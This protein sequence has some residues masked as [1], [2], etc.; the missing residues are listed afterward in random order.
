MGADG[1]L[2]ST[3]LAHPPCRRVYRP[4]WGF[5]ACH[6]QR[7]AGESFTN[8]SSMS[9]IV[10]EFVVVADGVAAIG[11]VRAGDVARPFALLGH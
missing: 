8:L 11:L 1:S 7:N 2:V 3:P 6:T 10:F 9:A 4:R 5:A